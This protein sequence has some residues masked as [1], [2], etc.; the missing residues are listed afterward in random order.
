M[1]SVKTFSSRLG[2]LALTLACGAASAQTWQT[3]F[4]PPAPRSEA[5]P[6]NATEPPG[7]DPVG[8][9]PRVP[10]QPPGRRTSDLI[11][12]A[13]THFQAG[14]RRYFEGDLAGA[15]REFD[16]AI[17]VLLTAPE[18]GR[19]QLNLE[20][21]FDEL[22]AAI[23]YYDLSGL[24][25][26]DTQSDPVFERSPLDDI[27][28][29]TFPIDPK[30]KNKVLDEVRATASQLP[31]EVNDPV[32]SY[33]HYFSSERGR[34]IL[35]YGL[36]R[37]GRYRPMIQRILDEEG[38]P[39]ELIY[40]AQAESGFMPRAL[41][42]KQ[43][44]GM[45]QFMQSRGKQ[46]GLEQTSYSDDRLNPEKATRS[47]AR[48]LRDLYHRY[49]DWYLAMAAYNCGPGVIDRAVERTGYVDFWE[50]RR[51]SVLPKETA[52][53]IPIILAMTIMGKNAQEYG[54]DNIDPDPALQ[55]DT[56][57]IQAP[58]S[59][60]LVAD[61]ANTT[62]SEIRELNP[63]L[64]R[65]TAPSGY[66]LNIPKGSA[67]AVVAG[68]SAVPENRRIAWRVHRVSEGDTLASIAYRYKMTEKS[69]SVA[70]PTLAGNPE[71]GDLVVVPAAEQKEPV[72]KRAARRAGAAKSG[73]RL[74]AS[75]RRTHSAKAAPTTGA[76][77]RASSQTRSRTQ[78]K[79]LVRS[80]HA[81]RG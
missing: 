38:V 23:H 60:L 9:L 17:D 10:G 69:L 44:T 16:L 54:L 7:L 43:A 15:R 13:D 19:S 30:I 46:Y 81:K 80:R 61:L 70:N 35:V 71:P 6:F 67:P 8:A 4:L 5:L 56:I 26:G 45:W 76:A 72:V 33:V 29:M 77:H 3:S 55:Y 11:R 20:K 63:A 21:K 79:A 78:S 14:K 49:G 47:A 34:K 51:R 64:L 48:H 41:S 73:K 42:R 75:A 25:A 39:Q 12:E 65:N 18:T 59:L 74:R 37:S 58:T 1:I 53:Y 40:L 68:L 66:R 24:G 32:L 57:E 22:V 52:N 27:P 62:I 50:L 28:Q 36:R 31:L 2:F